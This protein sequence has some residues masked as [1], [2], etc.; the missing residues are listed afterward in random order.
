MNIFEYHLTEIHNLLKANK[1]TLK[2]DKINNFKNVNLKPLLK[3]LILICL[4]T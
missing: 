1:T 4:V 3:S 2:L